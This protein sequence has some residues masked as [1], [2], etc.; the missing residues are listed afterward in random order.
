M[1]AIKHQY[2][3]ATFH[4]DENLAETEALYEEDLSRVPI[5]LFTVVKEVLLVPGLRYDLAFVLNVFSPPCLAYV[6]E[7][8]FERS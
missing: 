6:D 7:D 8:E 4:D 2:L 3:L 5:F 1:S